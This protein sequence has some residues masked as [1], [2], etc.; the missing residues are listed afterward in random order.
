[1]FTTESSLMNDLWT[2]RQQ[3]G[4]SS[5]VYENNFNVGNEPS[6]RELRFTSIFFKKT[7]LILR[8]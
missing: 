5:A 1:M 4:D 7:R 2:N 8:Y 6:F 3:Y